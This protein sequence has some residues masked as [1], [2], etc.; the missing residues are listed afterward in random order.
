ML[1]AG[2]AIV[3]RDGRNWS[4]TDPAAMIARSMQGGAQLFVDYEHASEVRAPKGEAAPAA[5]WI[6]QL[7]LR[8]GAVWARVE[9]TP[10]ASEMVLNREYRFISPVF[11]F[12]AKS[13]EV[14]SLVSAALTNTPNLS[15]T[16]LNRAEDLDTQQENDTM[17]K[18]WLKALCKKLGLQAEASN[19][20]ILAAVDALNGEKDR[21]LNSANSPSLEKFVPRA[22]YDKVIGERDAA[23]TA[24]N[25]IKTEK[26]EG[27]IV[28]AVDEAVKGGKIAPASKD[29]YLGVCRKEGGLAEFKKFVDTAPAITT[30]SI[31]TR[32]PVAGNVDLTIDEKAACKAM[33]ITEEAF[34]KARA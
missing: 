32:T 21:A 17:D 3:G 20:A 11:V 29:F 34:K 6:T 22:D 5:G 18:E 28:A 25:T 23:T 7:E 4:L 19:E 14:H 9:W 1:P 13:R 27:E 12:D 31:E 33:G 15:M 26:S 24:L 8:E 2:P 30:P 16:A 10:R